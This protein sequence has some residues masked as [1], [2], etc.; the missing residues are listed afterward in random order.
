MF[1]VF[2]YV[3]LPYMIL[4]MQAALERVP[5][6]MIKA[7]QDLGTTRAQTFRTVILP[8]TLPGVIAGSILTFSPAMGD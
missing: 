6:V 1:P 8:L 7:S 5:T 2:T 3:W 4:P